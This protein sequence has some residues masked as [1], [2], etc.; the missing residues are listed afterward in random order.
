MAARRLFLNWS[1]SLLATFVMVQNLWAEQTRRPNVVIILADDMGYGD[2]GCYG[3]EWLK[4]KNIDQLAREGIRFT[5]FHSS[6]TV[7]SPTRAGLMTGRYQQRA[8]IDGV[9]YADPQRN[10]H[11]G[12][13]SR[14]IVLAELLKEAGYVT[15]IFGKWHLGYRPVYN[16]VR[17]GFDIFRGY[18]SGNVDYLSHVDGTGV[19]DWWHNDELTVEEGYSTH[20][21]TRHAVQFIERNHDRPFLLYVAHEAVH[22]PYQAPNDAPVRAIGRKR[23]PEAERQDIREAYQQMMT[24]MDNGIGE[25]LSALRQHD[26]ERD[27]LV[28]FFS[29]NGANRNGSNGPLRGFK[30][31]VWEGGHRVPAIVRWTGHIT[32]ESV[33][34]AT[35]MSIDLM[36]TIL[37]VTNVTAPPDHQLDGVNLLPLLT[38]STPLSERSLYW[39]YL[40]KSAVREGRWKLVVSGEAQSEPQLFDLIADLGEQQDLAAMQPGRVESMLGRLQEWQHAVHTGATVQPDP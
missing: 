18:V 22:S 10:R 19:A 15:G 40:D 6:G 39:E 23:I 9:V 17:H 34:E 8:G 12:L 28:F 33:C 14:E 37:A 31:S 5:D 25:L 27:T 13:Q 30:G 26:L 2:A 36:P 16:P 3:S 35:A 1:L 32:P 20:L 24:E 11:H 4:T 21:I 29:D 7:C 38:E